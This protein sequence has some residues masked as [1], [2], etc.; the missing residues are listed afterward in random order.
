MTTTRRWAIGVRTRSI[1]TTP[2]RHRQGAHTRAQ[3]DRTPV[4]SP[5]SRVIRRLARRPAYGTTASSRR[6]QAA[7]DRRLRRVG[8]LP[9]DPDPASGGHYEGSPEPAPP[10]GPGRHAVATRPL[11]WGRNRTVTSMSSGEI[12]TSGAATNSP[13]VKARFDA[14]HGRRSDLGRTSLVLAA[15][16]KIP[17]SYDRGDYGD[18]DS[19]RRDEEIVPSERMLY[20]VPDHP[21]D[22]GYHKNRQNDHSHRT[23]PTLVGQSAHAGNVAPASR[24]RQDTWRTRPGPRR[25][26]GDGTWRP[27]CGR[28]LGTL[29]TCVMSLALLCLASTVS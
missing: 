14:R 24:T 13:S 17:R 9:Y 6:P 26:Y 3:L 12:P 18:K 1:S 20:Q 7:H 11:R 16:P 21:D 25:L 4:V 29:P 10:Q 15:G 19:A 2:G 27:W 28:P 5:Q 23:E 22:D 8:L